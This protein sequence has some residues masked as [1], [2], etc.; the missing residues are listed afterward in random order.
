VSASFFAE[1]DDPIS[2]F[3][4][5][6]SAPS[7]L[8]IGTEITLLRFLALRVGYNQGYVSFG[9]GWICGSWK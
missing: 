3:S 6:E 9:A 5:I 2:L 4:D 8:H 7:K 1:A